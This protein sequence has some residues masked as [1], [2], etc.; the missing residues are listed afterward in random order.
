M[1]KLAPYD[2]ELSGPRVQQAKVE[3]PWVIKSILCMGVHNVL[4]EIPTTQE[5]GTRQIWVEIHVPPLTSCV[6]FGKLV[7]LSKSQHPGDNYINPTGLLE[8]LA[9]IMFIEH[10][11]RCL[12]HCKSSVNVRL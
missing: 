4:Y 8:G 11:T 9:G 12:A 2:K 5:F 7:N 3:K 10:V 1:H 6:I